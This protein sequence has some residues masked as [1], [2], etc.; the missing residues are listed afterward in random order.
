M[1]GEA[2]SNPKYTDV[3]MWVMNWL[4][5]SVAIKSTRNSLKSKSKPKADKSLDTTGQYSRYRKKYKGQS[6]DDM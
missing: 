4:D 2:P 3:V 6:I 5:K 1:Y